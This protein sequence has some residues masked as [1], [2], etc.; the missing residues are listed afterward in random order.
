MKMRCVAFKREISRVMCACL[1]VGITSTIAIAD[2]NCQRLEALDRQYRGVALTSSQK[3]V[4]RQLVAW[5]RKNCGHS[6]RASA[7]R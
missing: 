3:Q 5:Y 1:L 2:D 4:K 7:R 6:R